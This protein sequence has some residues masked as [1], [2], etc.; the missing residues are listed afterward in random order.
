MMDRSQ[1]MLTGR[2][3]ASTS[4]QAAM[5][6]PLAAAADRL[7]I[8]F[9]ALDRA[10]HTIEDFVQTYFPLHGLDPLKARIFFHLANC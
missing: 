1:P 7:C 2:A 8:S 5:T 9:R 3:C 6:T 4:L 10:Q